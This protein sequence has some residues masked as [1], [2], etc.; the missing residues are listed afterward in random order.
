[1]DSLVNLL[2]IFRTSFPK[3]TSGWLLLC[4]AI[5]YDDLDEVYRHRLFFSIVHKA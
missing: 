4:V 1:M 3:N 5:Y 2:H